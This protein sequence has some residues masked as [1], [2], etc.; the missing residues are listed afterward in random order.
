MGRELLNA[1]GLILMK[2]GGA[3]LR[4]LDV[5]ADEGR[6]VLVDVCRVAASWG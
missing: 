2:V 4:F 1:I 3:A 6:S 5:L